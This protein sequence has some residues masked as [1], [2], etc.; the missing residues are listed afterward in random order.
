MPTAASIM[1]TRG[2]LSTK[3][4]ERVHQGQASL[5][6]SMFCIKFA[7]RVEVCPV[8]NMSAGEVPVFW[9]ARSLTERTWTLL[10]SGF[11]ARRSACPYENAEACKSTTKRRSNLSLDVQITLWRRFEGEPLASFTL[12]S[13]LASIYYVVQRVVA[14]GTLATP[15]RR[16]HRST[17]QG[18]AYML[19]S[20]C[21]YTAPFLL[22]Q[23]LSLTR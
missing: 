6:S 14:Q 13:L 2:A 8:S 15:L 21:L 7:A 12:Y 17:S 22:L 10:R 4:A 3:L 11:P 19:Q 23:F 16:A 18:T 5:M 20:T 9:I 1:N